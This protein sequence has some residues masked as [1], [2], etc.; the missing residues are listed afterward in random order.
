MSLAAT[1]SSSTL[2]DHLEHHAAPLSSVDH[3]KK[4]NLIK[5][6]QDLPDAD[7]S[8]PTTPKPQTSKSNGKP[9]LVLMGQKR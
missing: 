6:L 4:Q 9:K 5:F 7:S 3:R 1:V 8:K 2:F